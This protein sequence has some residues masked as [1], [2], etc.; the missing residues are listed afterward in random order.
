MGLLRYISF[1]SSIIMI[2]CNL[3]EKDTIDSKGQFSLELKERLEMILARD[4]GIREIIDGNLSHDRKL[5]ILKQLGL[6]EK[7]IDGDKKFELMQE[8]DSQNLIEI[9]N[10]INH[11][12]YPGKKVVGE[13]ANEAIFYVIQHSNKI[14]NYLPLIREAASKGD[15]SK[16]L[17]AMM[18]DRN[19]MEKGIE[20]KYGTQLKGKL[21]KNGQ[22]VFYLWPL[23]NPD[24]VDFWRNRAGFH[25][26]LEEYLKEMDVPFVLYSIKELNEI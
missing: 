2:S 17:L 14:E 16:V 15:I 26:T 19:L 6:S 23:K 11:Y 12:G 4:Q 5:E 8:I 18:E 25:Q 7:E 1:L 3:N 24:S 13:P 22:W 10:I 21:N 20:Q 9:E